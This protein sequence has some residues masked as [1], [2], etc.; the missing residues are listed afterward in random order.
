MPDLINSMFRNPVVAAGQH[1]APL[2]PLG[3]VAA[4]R[5]ATNTTVATFA[6]TAI[7]IS[8]DG[9]FPTAAQLATPILPSEA[10]FFWLV[11]KSSSAALA[12]SFAVNATNAKAVIG[13]MG[14]RLRFE[15]SG[16]K[17]QPK[18]LIADCVPLAKAVVTGGAVAVHAND[19]MR[20]AETGT[21][22][23]ATSMALSSEGA[24]YAPTDCVQ[25]IG[26]GGGGIAELLVAGLGYSHFLIF[27][28]CNNGGSGSAATK[29]H[30]AS[31]EC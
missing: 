30:G 23:W 7:L 5:Q 29:V 21:L 6:P 8:H 16:G 1:A 12:L 27:P 11:R 13:V 2:V 10:G 4:V 20:G 22:V 24:N 31:R 19:P 25:A 3:D 15:S 14:A 28:A 9:K 26:S 17:K 18:N